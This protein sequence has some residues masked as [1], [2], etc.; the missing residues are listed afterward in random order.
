MRGVSNH[1]VHTILIF[2]THNALTIAGIIIA[3]IAYVRTIIYFCVSHF[4]VRTSA[5]YSTNGTKIK[6]NLTHRPGKSVWT[7]IRS[8]IISV[9]RT[10]KLYLW[11]VHIF[12]HSVNIPRYDGRRLYRTTSPLSISRGLKFF[13]SES[14]VF[15]R[16]RAL[17]KFPRGMLSHRFVAAMQWLNFL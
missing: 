3:H 17:R 5:L 1:S 15:G 9:V 13:C 2:R 4:Y 12:G 14:A 6:P 7:T 8:V 16:R 10:H 11:G